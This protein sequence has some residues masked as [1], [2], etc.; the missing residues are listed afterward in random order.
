MDTLVLQRKH[1]AKQKL[2]ED[3]QQEA[4]EAAIAKVSLAVQMEKEER[5][6]R[7]EL[8]LLFEIPSGVTIFV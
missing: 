6:E 7:K 2:L 1:A 8:K 4:L 3:V 5:E